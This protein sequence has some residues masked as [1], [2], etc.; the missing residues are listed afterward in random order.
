MTAVVIGARNRGRGG[1]DI[2]AAF[3]DASRQSTGVQTNMSSSRI[4]SE[5]DDTPMRKA[6]L[7]VCTSIRLIYMRPFQA[8]NTCA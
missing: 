8:L 4:E 7:A 6:R 1:E 3:D 5:V 2:V